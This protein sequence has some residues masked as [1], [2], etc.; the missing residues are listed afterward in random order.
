MKLFRLQKPSV[1][2]ISSYDPRATDWLLGSHDASGGADSRIGDASEDATA[3]TTTAQ[4]TPLSQT[5]TETL[6]CVS[7]GQLLRQPGSGQSARAV[8]GQSI[9]LPRIFCHSVA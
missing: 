9:G 4:T 3:T 2:S 7:Q 1:D 5:D 6:N 8:R